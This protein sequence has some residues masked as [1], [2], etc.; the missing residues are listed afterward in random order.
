[1]SEIEAHLQPRVAVLNSVAARLYE[2]WI[3][4]LKD[5]PL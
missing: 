1:V 2:H 3:T 5:R 4:G